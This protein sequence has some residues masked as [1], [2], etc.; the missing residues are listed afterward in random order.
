MIKKIR[1]FFGAIA[2][3]FAASSCSD[4]QKVLKN[5][6]VKAKYEMAQDFYEKEDYK[7]A[8]RLFEQILPLYRGKPQGERITFFYANT[9]LKTKDYFLAAYQF[10]TFSKAFPKSDKL[11]EALYSEAFCYYKKSPIF[12]LDQSSTV[13]ALDKLQEFINR[14]PDSEFMPQANRIA[15]ELQFKL[16]KKA[17]EIAKQYNSIRDYKAAIVALNSFIAN[18]PGTPF[19]EDALFYQF[20]SSYQLGVNS[21]ES[22]KLERLKKAKKIYQSLVRYYP[23]SKYQKKSSKMMLTID[24]EITKFVPTKKS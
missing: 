22:K 23:E 5:D 11:P 4:Y 20:D 9:L 13:E 1:Y 6:D 18:Y 16:E 17:F 12:S 2:L 19:R 7:R 21:V 14:Y 3:M 8:S 15:Q 10:E 24:K